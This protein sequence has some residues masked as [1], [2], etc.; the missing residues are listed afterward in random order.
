MFLTGIQG[1]PVTNFV[2]IVSKFGLQT[3]APSRRHKSSAWQSLCHTP[4]SQFQW[5]IPSIYNSDI[6][7]YSLR[8]LSQELGTWRLPLIW[9]LL[10][11]A[12][13]TSQYP[14]SVGRWNHWFRSWQWPKTPCE[15]DGRHGGHSS[16]RWRSWNYY[17]WVELVKRIWWNW[18]VFMVLSNWNTSVFWV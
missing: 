9:C 4:A 17:T 14:R 5:Q 2:N 3:A 12:A 11:A 10:L 1:I 15:V 18:H 16:H 8:C 7:W 6:F 13:W